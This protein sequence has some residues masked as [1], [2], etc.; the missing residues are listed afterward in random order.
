MIGSYQPHHKRISCNI[1]HAAP[2]NVTHVVPYSD[3]PVSC[4]QELPAGS[5][6]V[7]MMPNT[8]ALVQNAASVFCRGTNTLPEDGE[9]VHNIVSTFGICEEMEEKHLDA[10]TG[11]S[12]SGP[13]FVSKRI[14]K[15]ERFQTDN[16]SKTP[17]S[18]RGIITIRMMRVLT[19]N[20]YTINSSQFAYL[21]WNQAKVL[22]V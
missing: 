17:I 6:V 16:L 5:R 12:G 4:S 18:H 22:T 11:L 9:T 13:A 19:A 10:V 8:P 20:I 14:H 15:L 21:V 2:C 3:M 1:K 7:R